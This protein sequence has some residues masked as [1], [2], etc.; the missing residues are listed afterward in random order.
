M[1]HT[2]D[3]SFKLKSNLNLNLTYIKKTYR[4][5]YVCVKRLLR[6]VKI[7][8]WVIKL[9]PC[10]NYMINQP[11]LISTAWSSRIQTYSKPKQGHGP[12]DGQFVHSDRHSRRPNHT[13][14]TRITWR[15]PLLWMSSN[16]FFFQKNRIMVVVNLHW[17]AIELSVIDLDVEKCVDGV[18]NSR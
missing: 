6:D 9:V 1:L 7:I 3:T 16:K 8:I 18:E 4:Y 10:S 2:V 11:C 15:C 17:I 14:T 13:T 5:M 12:T